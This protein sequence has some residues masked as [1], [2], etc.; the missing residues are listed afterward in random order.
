MDKFEMGA[1]AVVKNAWQH[2]EA[3]QITDLYV[4]L[5]H[6]AD[7]LEFAIDNPRRM[8]VASCVAHDGHRWVFQCGLVA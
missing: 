1:G 3:M 7:V 6:I 2:S 5:N 8:K 4:L